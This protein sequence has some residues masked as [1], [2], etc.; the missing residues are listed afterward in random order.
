MCDAAFED[1][2]VSRLVK[3]VGLPHCALDLWAFEG[4]DFNF[5][6]FRALVRGM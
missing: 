6:S 5:G 4:Q 1:P 2:R 3:L